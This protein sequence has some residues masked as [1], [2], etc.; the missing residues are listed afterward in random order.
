[1]APHIL[2]LKD[3]ETES[4]CQSNHQNTPMFQGVLILGTP[5]HHSLPAPSLPQV[6]SIHLERQGLFLWGALIQTRQKA[7][8]KVNL[9]P[10]HH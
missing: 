9:R 7:Q 2:L 5:P 1:M 10:E 8:I 6:D 4:L 3:Q